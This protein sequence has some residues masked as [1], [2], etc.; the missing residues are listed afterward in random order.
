MSL[1]KYDSSSPFFMGHVIQ[2][3]TQADE[4]LK[5]PVVS[6]ATAT[7]TG[8]GT[9]TLWTVPEGETWYVK[10]FE[11]HTGGADFTFSKCTVYDP[12]T[13]KFIG[14]YYSSGA[15]YAFIFNTPLKMLQDWEIR[16]VVDTFTSGGTL[17]A[18]IYYDKL[19]IEGRWTN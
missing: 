4:A 16:V 2:P 18:R 11:A 8:T 13:G 19:E 1:W 3:I 6:E 9:E 15:I 14:L 12:D 10:A 7:V 5:F 17:T